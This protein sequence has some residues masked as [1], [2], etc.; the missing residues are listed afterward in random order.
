MKKILLIG[1]SVFNPCYF[2]SRIS[3]NENEED[4][5]SFK[6]IL[7]KLTN[8]EI[9]TLAINGAGNDW[10]INA[11]IMN[12][13]FIDKD[14]MV[15]IYWAAVN[16]YDMFF[17]NNIQNSSISFPRK[18]LVPPH[19]KNESSF[20]KTYGL[21]GE[22]KETG[23]RFYSTGPTYP[24]IKREYQK[25]GYG[26][27]IHLKRF[28]EN[29]ILVQNLLKNKCYQQYHILPFDIEKYC[30]L[31]LL[32]PD[33][34]FATN[35]KFKGYTWIDF[36]EPTFDL[37]NEY[38]ELNE[39]KNLINWNFFTE[40][41]VEYFKKRNLPYWAGFNEHNIHQVPINNYYFIK[42]ELLKSD[43]DLEDFYLEA[44]KLHCEKFKINYPNLLSDL[45]N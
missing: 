33:G 15:I 10:P 39:W 21:N 12:K 4:E 25:I 19:I 22:D 43:I 44:T 38:P 34:H 29:V 42:D 45:K 13:N 27:G 30:E 35:Y 32:G 14:T 37:I 23:L 20:F 36:P 18:N 5:F 9:K 16:R 41:Y 40:N 1:S 7:K 3:G 31:Q 24:G 26:H 6:N 2:N 17:D 11:V 8:C 28:Y